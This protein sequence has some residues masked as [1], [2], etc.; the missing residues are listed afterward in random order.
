MR[1]ARLR[2]CDLVGADLAGAAGPGVSALVW[3]R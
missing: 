3:P 1:G 2:D